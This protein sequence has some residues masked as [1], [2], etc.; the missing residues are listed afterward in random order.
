M[1][2]LSAKPLRLPRLCSCC[3]PCRRTRRTL[4]PPPHPTQD[5]LRPCTPLPTQARKQAPCRPS[6]GWAKMSGNKARARRSPSCSTTRVTTSAPWPAA[7]TRRWAAR[8]LCAR[9]TA[10]KWVVQGTTLSCARMSCGEHVSLAQPAA[11]LCTAAGAAERL[12]MQRACLCHACIRCSIVRFSIE[13]DQEILPWKFVASWTT[14][15]G[16]RLAKLPTCCHAYPAHPT[17]LRCVSSL[18]KSLRGVEQLHEPALHVC[19]GSRCCCCCGSSSPAGRCQHASSRSFTLSTRTRCQYHPTAHA[20]CIIL[21]CQPAP[22]ACTVSLHPPPAPSG[23]R[24]ATHLLW[25]PRP[26]A[27]LSLQASFLLDHSAPAWNG[28]HRPEAQQQQQQLQPPSQHAPGKPPPP[29][30]HLTLY[31]LSCSVQELQLSLCYDDRWAC[32][33]AQAKSH[34]C[35]MS[36]M[37]AVQ[38]AAVCPCCREHLSH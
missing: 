7:C 25:P 19:R 2:A 26:F 35:G 20:A 28:L 29:R 24:A 16:S 32:K 14:W 18:L 4:S 34:S 12:Q 21:L 38:A 1:L 36:M 6:W 10:S 31:K 13:G 23:S 37:V 15:Q 33:P 22:A 8:A 27:F 30:R 17:Q 9:R 3:P 5:R 11:V